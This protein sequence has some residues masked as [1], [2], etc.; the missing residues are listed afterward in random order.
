MLLRLHSANTPTSGTGFWTAVSSNPSVATFTNANDPATTING[1]T[2]GT[3]Q[4]VWTIS[5]AVCTESKDTVQ[6]IV[7]P[8]TVAGKIVADDFV[9]ISGNNGTVK[10]TGQ[11]GKCIIMGVFKRQHNRMERSWQYS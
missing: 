9:C 8:P 3:Y 1:L 5:N 4:F 7:Y 11:T 6:I 2:A 10:L